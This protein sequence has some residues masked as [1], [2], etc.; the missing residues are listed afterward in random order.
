MRWDY[1]IRTLADAD[2]L[3]VLKKMG[4]EGWEMIGLKEEPRSGTPG[5]NDAAI[6]IT[7]WFKRPI[8]ESVDMR[9]VLDH[10]KPKYT[11]DQLLAEEAIA[12]VAVA[13]GQTTTLAIPPESNAWGD[14]P[15]F[16][17]WDERRAKCVP[18]KPN[19]VLA[20]ETFNLTVVIDDQTKILRIMSEAGWYVK[21]VS[22]DRKVDGA[23]VTYMFTK[24]QK[25]ETGVAYELEE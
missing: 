17:E 3:T 1:D 4:S 16:Q 15:E 6:Y 7:Y 8:E 14:T 24:R 23:F 5:L 9:D 2:R 11:M 22:K 18:S 13:R 21:D 10:G 19:F 12:A 20:P 25:K